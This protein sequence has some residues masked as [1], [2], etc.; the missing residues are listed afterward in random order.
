MG[1]GKK[2]KNRKAN[3]TT[4]TQQ[5]QNNSQT[6]DRAI[7]FPSEIEQILDDE[8]KNITENA[9]KADLDNALRNMLIRIFNSEKDVEMSYIADRFGLKGRKKGQKQATTRVALGKDLENSGLTK[10]EIKAIMEQFDGTIGKTLDER[11]AI[12]REIKDQLEATKNAELDKETKE[13]F[14]T[15]YAEDKK[16]EAWTIHEKYRVLRDE[17]L[18]HEEEK[19]KLE[20]KFAQL[21]D[22]LKTLTPDKKNQKK[23]DDLTARKDIIEKQIVVERGEIAK[24]DIAIGELLGKDLGKFKAKDEA[25]K[26]N[27]TTKKANQIIVENDKD[28]VLLMKFASASD[29]KSKQA[30]LVEMLDKRLREFYQQRVTECTQKVENAR[31]AENTV[32]ADQDA[33]LKAL[34][35]NATKYMAK[36]ILD[37]S[38][39]CQAEATRLGIQGKLFG[40]EFEKNFMAVRYKK[41]QVINSFKTKEEKTYEALYPNKDVAALLEQYQNDESNKEVRKQ[42]MKHFG[43]KGLFKERRLDT[44]IERFT[45]YS[46]ASDDIKVMTNMVHCD[47]E[48]D[49]IT[50]ILA[51]DDTK[52]F[53]ERLQGLT[54]TPEGKVITLS[55]TR[56]REDEKVENNSKI[57]QVIKKTLGVRDI[58]VSQLKDDTQERKQEVVAAY[59][60]EAE[61]FTK[62]QPV[63]TPEAEVPEK[64]EPEA[65]P[66]LEVP[67]FDL[68]SVYTYENIILEGIKCESASFTGAELLAKCATMKLEEIE[69]KYGQET[70]IMIANATGQEY[71]HEPE[72]EVPSVADDEDVAKKFDYCFGMNE[73][74]VEDLGL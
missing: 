42:L 53:F 27:Y 51:C 20:E 71:G 50:G 72:V 65:T 70:A 15:E 5:T 25:A 7:K 32:V 33:L 13:F 24:R 37:S 59:E 58:V 46:Q 64:A 69:E 67:E 8:L 28:Q 6:N 63:A 10:E 14:L 16:E 22:D 18:K 62:T 57:Q 48:I 47:K 12:I 43:I 26:E 23:I 52:C 44:Q 3:Q 4:N 17:R 56:E 39:E 49:L 11:A 29:A 61:E 73:K 9:Q 35:E 45:Q 2:N 31:N 66:E 30:V 38:Q 74:D 36:L 55:V 40:E 60:L 21:E 41:L 54:R 68:K 19:E 1:K 34:K